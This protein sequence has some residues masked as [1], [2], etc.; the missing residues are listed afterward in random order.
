MPDDEDYQYILR[1]IE[2]YDRKHPGEIAAM[3]ED[4]KERSVA[5]NNDWG[6]VKAR[7]LG[8]TGSD[9]SGHRFM[10]SLPAELHKKIEAYIPTM[11][12]DKKHF[13]WFKQKFPGLFIPRK[14]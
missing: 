12:S 10:L 4:A 7:G 8:K 5:S 9:L 14:M 1:L 11:F 6:L 13:G 3:R 2:S